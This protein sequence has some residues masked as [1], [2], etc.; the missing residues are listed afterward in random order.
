MDPA[1]AWKSLFEGWPDAIPRAGMI[2]TGFGEAIPFNGFMVSGGLLVIERETPDQFG[3]RKVIL[4][5]GQ[6][7]A[8]RLST[9]IELTRFAA[10]GF[11]P[12]M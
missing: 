6:V 9:T 4:P 5:Y 2:V 11:Q 1:V 12:P 7:A 10:M 3:T 8:V